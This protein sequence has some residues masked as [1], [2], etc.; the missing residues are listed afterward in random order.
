M[1]IGNIQILKSSDQVKRS[2]R[3]GIV[4]KFALQ[5]S[6]HQQSSVT[7]QEMSFYTVGV[8]MIYR[9]ASEVGLHDTELY[10]V[11]EMLIAGTTSR[12]QVE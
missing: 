5:E 10:S 8:A 3:S 7:D 6:V 12:P 1:D 4:N 2:N 9:P 11:D